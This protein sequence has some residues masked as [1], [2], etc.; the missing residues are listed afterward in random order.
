[1][2]LYILKLHCLSLTPN[3]FH[4]NLPLGAT[5]VPRNCP[6]EKRN[7]TSIVSLTYFV[8]SLQLTPL[9]LAMETLILDPW[10]WKIILAKFNQVCSFTAL[11]Y[12][13]LPSL[14]RSYKFPVNFRIPLKARLQGSLVIVTICFL[15]TTS[16]VQ[17]DTDEWQNT[18]F[19]ITMVSVVIMTGESFCY[20]F[21][22][23][24]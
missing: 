16:F 6:R 19:I 9:V 24:N 1:M 7:R 3:S 15:V 8:N 20:V 10:S 21:S 23:N 12:S 5:D 18:F 17:V 13:T 11:I 14:S 22:F 2:S 4:N